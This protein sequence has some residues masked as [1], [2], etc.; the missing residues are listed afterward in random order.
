[1]EDQCLR[2]W[3][4]AQEVLSSNSIDEVVHLQKDGSVITARVS[5]S[6]RT[7]VLHDVL[8]NWGCC[9]CHRATQ[10]LLCYHHVLALL[11]V[12]PHASTHKTHF[13]GQL[14]QIAGRKFGANSY[15]HRGIGGIQPLTD[16]LKGAEEALLKKIA[17]GAVQSS[18]GVT[19]KLLRDAT[20]SQ[21]QEEA[22]VATGL[23]AHPIAA[24]C[25]LVSSQQVLSFLHVEVPCN[26]CDM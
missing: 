23:Q 16:K 4:K 17:P 2:A 21:V 24:P 1:M 12:F 14:L 3:R 18:G 11:A 26:A 20:D 7:Y 6:E 13:S 10:Q 19:S 5:G 22:L 9:T 15:C 8:R 25:T